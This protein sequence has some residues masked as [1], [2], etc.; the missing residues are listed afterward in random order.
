MVVRSHVCCQVLT[1]GGIGWVGMLLQ[2]GLQ[3]A[4]ARPLQSPVGRSSCCSNLMPG[5]VLFPPKPVPMHGGRSAKGQAQLLLL[6]HR[7]SL[8]TTREQAWV[9][10]C[11]AS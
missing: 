7:C 3:A 10:P 5:A 11:G 4:S 9:T 6:L 1:K 2:H 8:N